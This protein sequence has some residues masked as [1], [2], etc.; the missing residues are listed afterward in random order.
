MSTVI[1]S[2]LTCPDCGQDKAELHQIDGLVSPFKYQIVHPYCGYVSTVESFVHSLEKIFRCPQIGIRDRTLSA[3]PKNGAESVSY[4]HLIR[5]IQKQTNNFFETVNFYMENPPDYLHCL[6]CGEK[7]LVRTENNIQC[8]H[9]HYSVSYSGYLL[10]FIDSTG[11]IY[12]STV[13]GSDMVI[14][15]SHKEVSSLPLVQVVFRTF[16][17]TDQPELSKRVLIVSRRTTVPIEKYSEFLKQIDRLKDLYTL[18]IKKEIDD[19]RD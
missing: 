11:Y 9:K 6:V 12:S 18:I 10:A 13:K 3:F 4:G 2:G 14:L 17:D 19:V 5:E 16:P 8:P 1:S 7:T 15:I